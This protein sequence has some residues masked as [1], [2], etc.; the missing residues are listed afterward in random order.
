MVAEMKQPSGNGHEGALH[1]IDILLQELPR[2]EN[3]TVSLGQLT[4]AMEE[5]AFGLMLLI[6]AVPCCLP[7]IYLLPQIV[8][9]PMAV[10]VGQMAMGRKSPW[11]PEKLRVRRMPVEPFR[12]VLA[13]VQKYGGWLERLTHK[14]FAGL[15]NAFAARV[16]G[17]LLFIPCL[18]ILTPLPLTNTVP[19]VG[20]ALASAGLIERDGLFVVAGVLIALLWV[21]ALLIG[22]PTLIYLGVDFIL[23]R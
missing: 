6:L 9:V 23:N 4:D 3:G 2:D 7:F 21:A 16:V 5:R 22:G 12:G 1:K 15:T 18:S 8:A 20:V 10:L 19:G 14:R 17:A 11:L 13:K